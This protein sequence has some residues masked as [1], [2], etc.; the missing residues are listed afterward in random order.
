MIKYNDIVL[1]DKRLKDGSEALASKDIAVVKSALSGVLS[2]MAY[3]VSVIESMMKVDE[4]EAV[5]DITRTRKE[6]MRE[7][8]IAAGVDPTE[9]DIKELRRAVMERR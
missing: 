8:A 4:D 5:F 9:Q 3:L 6:E 1:W 2:D 7:I